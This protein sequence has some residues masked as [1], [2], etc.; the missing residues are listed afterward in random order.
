MNYVINANP[1]QMTY[2]GA[3]NYT[4]SQFEPLK[5]QSNWRV[6]LTGEPAVLKQ[7]YDF[8]KV[9][10]QKR[11]DAILTRIDSTRLGTFNQYLMKYAEKV[12]SRP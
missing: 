10:S 3:A 4:A 7:M 2:K 12:K 5:A 11:P 6:P 8:F 9:E 1:F